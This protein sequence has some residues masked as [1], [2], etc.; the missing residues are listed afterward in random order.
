MEE[1]E[2]REFT[3]TTIRHSTVVKMKDI[4]SIFRKYMDKATYKRSDD[5]IDRKTLKEEVESFRITITGMRNGKTMTAQVLEEYKKSILRIID[6]QPTIYA[7]DG[8]IPVEDRL[9]EETD[10]IFKKFKDTNKW[11]NAM[12]EKKS[13]EVNITYE[14]ED[15]TRKSGT[16]YTID[17]KWRCEK[18]DRLVKRKVIAWQPLP[19]SYKPKKHEK[20]HKN[21]QQEMEDFWNNK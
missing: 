18:E 4:R 15:G 14:L 9:P 8:W 13:E 5:L 7:N 6:E 21:T 1:I 10:S 3:N 2:S 11:S 20:E 17:G 16:S 12:W 19:E